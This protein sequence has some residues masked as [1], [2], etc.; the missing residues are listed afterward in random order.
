[1]ALDPN[2]SDVIGNAAYLIS[3]LGRL[4]DSIALNEWCNARDPLN[5]IGLANQG[6]NY[7]NAGRFPECVAIFR[8]V[9]R[10]APGYIG[11]HAGVGQALLYM[12]Q[13]EA[14][15]AETQKETDETQRLQT[16]AIVYHALGRE[17][18]SDAALA[19]VI[20]KHEKEAPYNIAEVYAYRNDKD[21]AFEWLDKA[22]SLHDGNLSAIPTD[23]LMT[24]LK[25]DPRW[26]PFLRK[27]G[28]A[29]EQLAAIPFEVKLPDR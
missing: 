3:S 19:E 18:E 25:S 23:L 29:P 26:L 10:L 22:V 11:V 16:M 8:T 12:G 1:L 4:D 13:P 17:A 2:N 24:N 5:A 15:L 27:I 7:F 28:K 21:R 9:L 20:A 14:A 6:G